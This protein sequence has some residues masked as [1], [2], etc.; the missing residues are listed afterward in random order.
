MNIGKQYGVPHYVA[1]LIVLGGLVAMILRILHLINLSDAQV[2]LIIL[3]MASILLIT[4]L[5]PLAMGAMTV[6]IA[7][8][9]TGVLPVKSAF[10][11]FSNENVILFGAMF[12]VGGAMFRTGVAQI[13]GNIVVKCANGNR[14]RLVLYVMIATG[15]LSSVM[16]NTGTVAVLMP[17]CI[18]IADSAGM[19]RKYLLLPLAMMASLG[20]MI[21]LIGTPPNI[22][23]STVIQEYGYEGFG[24]F[25]F[26]YTGLPLTIAGGAY[27]YFIYRKKLTM[28]NKNIQMEFDKKNQ[29]HLNQKQI[30]SILVLAAVVAVMATGIINLTL[31]AMIGAMTCL[32]LGLVNQ[33][34]AVEDIDWTTIFLFAGMLPLADALE[35]TGAGQIIADQAIRIIGTNTSDIVI[36]SVLYFIAVVLTQFMSNTAACALLAPIGMEIAIALEADPKA[37]VLVIAVASASAFAT[38]MATPPNTLVMGPAGAKFTDFVK[39]G[40][41]LILISYIVCI[42]IVPRVWPFF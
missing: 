22:T 26:A 4:E 20:G 9:L 33:Q 27:M 6:P 18:G 5:I 34:E 16:S 2:T 3:L 42:I 36:L 21:T 32:L 39:L 41:P 17:V 37:A 23:V 12:I 24:F 38:P 13:I 40:L 25:E 15:L 28:D 30:Q 7:I 10:S 35:Y 29:V 8:A 11:G 19:N 1:V 31:G 14:K